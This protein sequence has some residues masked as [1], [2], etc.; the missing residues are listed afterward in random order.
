MTELA[1]GSREETGMS[2]GATLSSTQT[3]ELILEKVREGTI[4]MS[5]LVEYVARNSRTDMEEVAAA[6]WDLI[7]EDRLAY[8]ANANVSLV[9]EQ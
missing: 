3:H 2:V 1:R 9:A 4:A 6:V 7:Q 8:N 5:N